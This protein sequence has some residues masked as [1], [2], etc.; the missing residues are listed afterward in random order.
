[1]AKTSD[2]ERAQ[3]F[4]RKALWDLDFITSKV[5]YVGLARKA[6]ILARKALCLKQLG[7]RSQFRQTRDKLILLGLEETVKELVEE[8]L[9]QIP[10]DDEEN[11]VEETQE[12]STSD[13][14]SDQLVEDEGGD[15][16]SSIRTVDSETGEPLK[17]QRPFQSSHEELEEHDVQVTLE[18]DKQESS[19]ELQ[20]SERYQ[21]ESERSEDELWISSSEAAIKSKEGEEVGKPELIFHE[22][23]IRIETDDVKGRHIKAVKDIPKGSVLIEEEASCYV[24]YA[25]A[26]KTRCHRECRS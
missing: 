1:M 13:Y 11:F 2:A 3:E 24:L 18:N 20:E 21:E 10:V 16:A 9:L 22:D 12:R 23:R 26:F 14:E 4:Y 5:G 19:R 7:K 8:L 6:L 25:Q 17:N 15:T